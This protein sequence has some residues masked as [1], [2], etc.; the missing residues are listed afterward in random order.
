MNTLN[1]FLS[2]AIFTECIIIAL[3]FL[4]YQSKTRDIFF[5]YFALSF[6]LL[7]AERIVW[8]IMGMTSEFRPMVYLFRLATFLV[9]IIAILKKNREVV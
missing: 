5:G 2:G 6:A 7:A 4:Q 3:F 8:S 1:F 9:I